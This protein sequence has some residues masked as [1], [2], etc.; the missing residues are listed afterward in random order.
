MQKAWKYALEQSFTQLEATKWRWC[1]GSIVVI[2]VSLHALLLTILQLLSAVVLHFRKLRYSQSFPTV[3]L[4]E[5][6]VMQS[7]WYTSTQYSP[8]PET[9]RAFLLQGGSWHSSA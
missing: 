2:V 1:C 8:H 5:P 4:T 6:L 3:M 7:G 9:Q